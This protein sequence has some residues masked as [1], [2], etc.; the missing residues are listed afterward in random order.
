MKIVSSR[1]LGHKYPS[2][3]P[4]SLNSWE[5]NMRVHVAVFGE[6]ESVGFPY[7]QSDETVL[8]DCRRENHKLDFLFRHRTLFSNNTLCGLNMN[9]RW[10][11]KLLESK[12]EALHL[13]TSTLSVF[14]QRQEEAQKI[15]NPRCR[16][17]SATWKLSAFIYILLCLC[18]QTI[19]IVMPL[20]RSNNPFYCLARGWC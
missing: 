15:R 18:F 3:S 6:W 14:S 12:P 7:N 11:V 2:G 16:S 4:S 10:N 19:W 17:W 8:Q 9:D 1:I 5:S 13:E 20:G